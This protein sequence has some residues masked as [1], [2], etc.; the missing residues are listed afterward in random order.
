M[1]IRATAQEEWYSYASSKISENTEADMSSMFLQWVNTLII[2][3]IHLGSPV[4]RAKA[5]L[6]MLK[7]YHF[8]RLIINGDLFDDL[9]FMRLTRDDWE[10][11][12]YLRKLSNPKY[13]V[14]VVWVWGNHDLFSS[15]AIS[16]LIGARVTEEY[17]WEENGERCLAIHGHQFDSFMSKN[18]LISAIAS[19]IYLFLQKLD[20]KNHRFSRFIKRLSKTWL[21]LSKEVAE[22]ALAHGSRKGVRNVFCSHTHSLFER[23]KDGVNYWNT[24]CWTEIPSTYITIDEAGVHV[25]TETPEEE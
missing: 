23:R 18:A 1:N 4:S 5:V 22:K 14:E 2:S 19:E 3:D 25:N 8:R 12:S 7:R 9:S 16:H 10:L 24:G 11:L 13:G 21:R 15:D 20:R 6:E 17:E